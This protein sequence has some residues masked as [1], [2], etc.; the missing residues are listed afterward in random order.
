MKYLLFFFFV[1]VSLD[2]YAQPTGTSTINP[3]TRL[4]TD[5]EA[6]KILMTEEVTI[7][8]FTYTRYN[9]FPKDSVDNQSIFFDTLSNILTLE[10][11]GQIDL[12]KLDAA[13]VEVHYDSTTYT[14]TIGNNSVSL[15]SLI[16]NTDD[17]QVSRNGHVVE[18]ERGGSFDL[19]EYEN[20]DNQALG[21]NGNYITLENGGQVDLSQFLDNT[22]SQ[23]LGIHYPNDS[24][25]VLS[26]SSGNS[27]TLHLSGGG[28]AA[29]IF[30]YYEVF[31]NASGGSLTATVNLG[32]LPDLNKL[33]VFRP[34][35][36]RL[37]HDSGGVSRDYSVSNSTIIFHE[38]LDNERIIISWTE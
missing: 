13:D 9:H 17:Q 22:D 6:G 21:R 37:S 18:L 31:D 3:R 28:G 11:G 29:Q 26:I 27:V 10:N 5:G 36:G 16:D 25:A 34:G 20:T 24:T 30:Q 35:I 7:G 14:L 4:R 32:A 33:H 1:L 12:T 38:P 23:L 8:G 2:T 15:Y 19:S